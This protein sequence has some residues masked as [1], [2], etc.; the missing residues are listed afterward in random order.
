MYE[1]L[2]KFEEQAEESQHLAGLAE[3]KIGFNREAKK[4]SARM[5]NKA[6][7]L[8]PEEARK[9]AGDLRTAADKAEGKD[10]LTLPAG[11]AKVIFRWDDG[12]VLHEAIYN[13]LNVLSGGPEAYWP[14]NHRRPD[15]W[16]RRRTTS[17]GDNLTV[18]EIPR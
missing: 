10:S 14:L 16:D 8:E 18:V 4:V 3:F 6:V 2:N 12:T 15:K 13:P 11:T 5:G 9:I 7:I 17:D 1:R